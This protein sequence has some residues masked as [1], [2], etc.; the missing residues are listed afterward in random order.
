MEKIKNKKI[1]KPR[2]GEKECESEKECE[3]ENVYMF[4]YVCDTRSSE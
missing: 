3:K 1:K 4:V 2:N